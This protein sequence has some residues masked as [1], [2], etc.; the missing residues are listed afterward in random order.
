MQL[1]DAINSKSV[2]INLFYI[3]GKLVKSEKSLSL[4]SEYLLNIQCGD[5]LVLR[6]I[7]VN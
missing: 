7:D 4:N 3:E 6:H 1:T 5:K 2:N